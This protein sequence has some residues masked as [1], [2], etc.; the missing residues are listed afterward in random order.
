MNHHNQHQNSFDFLPHFP[1]ELLISIFSYFNFFQFLQCL[2]V[3]RYWRNRLMN[4]VWVRMENAFFEQTP[5]LQNLNNIEERPLV[6]RW[7][8][9][10]PIPQIVMSPAMVYLTSMITGRH[11]QIQTAVMQEAGFDNIYRIF[12]MNFTTLRDLLLQ[13]TTLSSNNAQYLFNLIATN[14]TLRNLHIHR[15]HLLPRF[16]Y[17]RNQIPFLTRLTIDHID[18]SD[19]VLL[20]RFIDATLQQSIHL[21]ELVFGPNTFFQNRITY[22]IELCPPTLLSFTISANDAMRHPLRHDLHTIQH[23]HH[24]HPLQMLSLD[25]D[26]HTP[27]QAPSI[28]INDLNGISF[29]VANTLQFLHIHVP[30]G[31]SRNWRQNIN[32]INVLAAL[33]SQC[34]QLRVVYWEQHITE[35]ILAALAELPHLQIIHF[36]LY[37]HRHSPRLTHSLQTFFQNIPYSQLIEIFLLHARPRLINPDT[38][39]IIYTRFPNAIIYI[40]HR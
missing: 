35:V 19:P 11:C 12:I 36:D 29:Y 26:I 3:S 39:Q 37:H 32:V 16:V 22:I 31:R 21:Q 13:R 9:E 7:L 25:Y 28:S 8:H 18:A 20:F 6:G 40:P 15:I 4:V 5:E 23:P 27:P 17:T 33:V 38:E 34:R 2:D 10:L 30:W 14:T 1:N 24:I